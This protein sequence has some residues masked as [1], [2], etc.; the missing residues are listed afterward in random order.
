MNTNKILHWVTLVGLFAVPFIPLIVT[1]S[2]FFPFITGKNFAFRVIIEIVFASW[3]ILALRDRSYWPEKSYLLYAVLALVVITGI[4]T[5]FGENPYRSFWSNYERMG[6]YVSLLHLGAYFVVLTSLLKKKAE[7]FWF[8]N[9]SLGVNWLIV[10]YSLGQL[11]GKTEIHQGG[12]R[13]DATLGNATYL[14]VYVLFGIFISLYLLSQAKNIWLKIFYGLTTLVNLFL[15]YNTATRGTILGLIAGLFV[16]AGLVVLRGE[17]RQKKWAGGIVLV[18]VL[19][20]GGFLLAKDSSFVTNSPVLSR[21]SSISA[22]E[23]TTQ[24]RF[25]IWNMSLQG[26]KEHPLLGWGPENYSLVFS[27]YY[28]PAMWRQEPWFDRSHNIF[29]D[30]LIDAGLLGLLA[31]LSIFLVAFYLLWAKRGK[32]GF[33]GYLFVGLIV[34][35]L[36]HNI[37]VFDNL[38]SYLYFFAVVAY[39]NFWVAEE[40]GVPAELKVKTNYQIDKKKTSSVG[41]ISLGVNVASGVILIILVGVLY[42]INYKPWLVSVDLISAIRPNTNSEKSFSIF[43]EIFERKTFGSGEAREQLINKTMNIVRDEKIPD[44]LKIKFV[45]LVDEQIKEQLGRFD[46]DA[47]SNLFFGSYLAST[48]RV[49]EGLALLQ[50]AQA[51]SPK[52]QAILFQLVSIY[53]QKQDATSAVATAKSAYELDP[54]YPEA[55]KIYAIILFMTGQTKLGYEIIAPIKNDPDYFNDPRFLNIYEQM[56]DTKS[57]QEIKD[58][59]LKEAKK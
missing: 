26:F 34:A 45:K 23:A 44:E 37:F 42:Y 14:A 56:G 48:G 17:K 59:Q 6:G 1:S 24:S 58:L 47:R 15:L 50:K 51:L 32:L 7:W 20:V 22:T 21:F 39:V 8:A 10:F 40:G 33:G 54:A 29:F 30:W 4:A 11:A 18:L 55:R 28:D 36:F 9:I 35:Y 49:D 5:F 57:I 3:L 38:V 46:G 13:L 27:K 16:F 25:L 41:N 19:L 52:K 2:A 43:Q 53:V 12:V 31:Y